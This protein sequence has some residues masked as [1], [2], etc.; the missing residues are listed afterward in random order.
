[1]NFEERSHQ[2]KTIQ[3]S[4]ASLQ[5]RNAR[6]IS[7]LLFVVL[8]ALDAVYLYILAQG[9]GGLYFV[10]LWSALL[11]TF[12]TFITFRVARNNPFGT[13][14]LVLN[15]SI[16]ISSIATSFAIQGLGLPLGISSLLV[17]FQISGLTLESQKSR[18]GFLIGV[19]SGV[20]T[21]LADF[22]NAPAR[23]ELP[24]LRDFI[25]IVAAA[26]VM[27]Q[28]I[29]ILRE[30]QNFSLRTKLIIAFLNVAILALGTLTVIVNNSNRNILLQNAGASITAETESRALIVG[31]FLAKELQSLRA[32]SIDSNLAIRVITA[33]ISYGDKLEAEINDENQQL[34]AA[35][36]TADDQD[37]LIQRVLN[38]RISK[39]L[40]NYRDLFPYNVEVF[41]TDKYGANI[42]STNRTSDYYQADEGWWQSAYNNGT[43]SIFIGQP[44]YDESSGRYVI[45]IAVPVYDPNNGRV[46][47]ILR[48]N[49][50]VSELTL[51]L[52]SSR[53]AAEIDLNL[54][55]RG[56]IEVKTS[57]E[58]LESGE[59]SALS[60]PLDEPTYR[61]GIYDGVPSIIS[62]ARISTLETTV[63]TVIDQMGWSI[64]AHQPLEEILAQSQQQ[65]RFITIISLALLGLVTLGGYFASQYIA[66]PLQTLSTVTEQIS[67]G[68]LGKRANI[69][70]QD[71]I[72][73]L[74]RSFNQMAEN[75]QKNLT[76]LE[77]SVI[78]RTSELDAAR[79]QSERRA[80]ELQSISEISKLISTEKN[81]KV[82]MPLI[83]G[84]VSQRFGFYHSGIF[85][86]DNAEKFAVLEAASSE[87]GKV[88]LARGHRLE[89]GGS[90][91]V[92]HVAKAGSPRIAL[93]VGQDAVFFNNP[94]L[95][96]TRSEMALPLIISNKVGGV[97]DIQ[98]RVAGAFS[99]QELNTMSILADQ[100]AS[101]IE[102][103]RLFENAQQALREAESLYQQNIRE[104]W[105][106]FSAEEKSIGYHQGLTSGNALAIPVDSDE[107]RTAIN[108]GD[109]SIKNSDV[110][111]EPTIV[112]P[113]KL[114]GQVIGV[115]KI[116]AP[117]AD[118]NW[119]NDEINLTEVI[120]E[121]LSLALENARLIQESQSSAAKE[122]VISEVTS[123]ISSSINLKNILQTAVEELG[124]A[125]PGSEVLI[126]LQ[127][128]NDNSNHKDGDNHA[129]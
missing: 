26:I 95:P 84:L 123:R 85:L 35:W 121:R 122:Q 68:D 63:G 38:D 67:A 106:S 80:T 118:R 48:T 66:K 70:T 25:T 78:E 21:I 18:Q 87:G 16:A 81:L 91:I 53:L 56:G 13:A 47:G 110:S 75:L 24:A 32:L 60:I 90:G 10:G 98:S 36:R 5:R 57:G 77:Q 115:I 19:L 107:I 71:E 93:D 55:I 103:A 22:S 64:V 112:V 119:T 89:V 54:Y 27:I 15:A 39:T 124:N 113:I 49:V 62:R 79:I 51:T 127:S 52:E 46:E 7:L 59:F 126:K 30:F 108:R 37:E 1:M 69:S 23:I 120:S 86:L 94:D 100:I 29:L 73:A 8:L 116:N 20:G 111:A 28:T 45:V 6:L 97:L 125:I 101:V 58:G 12:T 31:D 76:Y 43:G 88:M 9:T 102:N 50:D 92:G 117:E 72:G 4:N 3:G 61:E 11:V 65:N 109:S 44:G 114:R 41:V 2:V 83:T 129:E 14:I 74:A 99:D 82:L 40:H 128:E 105:A 33:N 104:N 17:I 34:D 42:G 96:E